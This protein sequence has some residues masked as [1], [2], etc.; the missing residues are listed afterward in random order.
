MF[1]RVAAPAGIPVGVGL[2]EVLP[3]ENSDQNCTNDGKK[4]VTNKI[5]SKYLTG[6]LLNSQ[7]LTYKDKPDP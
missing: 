7:C 2:V 5:L 3:S 1:S 4:E 6:R